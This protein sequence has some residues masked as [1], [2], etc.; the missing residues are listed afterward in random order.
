VLSN[1]VTQFPVKQ[2]DPREQDVL[3]ETAQSVMDAYLDNTV[4]RAEA[5]YPPLHAPNLHDY[6]RADNH[7]AIRLLAQRVGG[8]RA[9]ATLV[10]NIAYTEGEAV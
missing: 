8:Y 5:G 2:P 4:D 9:L 1:N 7:Q 6:V 3:P 10:R